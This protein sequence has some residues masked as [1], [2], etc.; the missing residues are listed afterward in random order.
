[1]IR[2]S[3][4]R[5]KRTKP[6]RGRVIDKD[7]LAW[8]ARDRCAVHG[9][10]VCPGGWLGMTIHHVREFGSPKNDRHTLLLCAPTHL[11]T[12]DSEQS[13]EALGKTKWQKFHNVNIKAKI[14]DYNE[15][16]ES[17]RAA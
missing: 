14:I 2:R 5:K 9:D 7:F 17:E 6:R 12:I 13:I 1:M 11:Q 15:R 8:L 10:R 3:P 4:I 16:Y